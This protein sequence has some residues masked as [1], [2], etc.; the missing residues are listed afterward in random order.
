[1]GHSQQDDICAM[2]FSTVKLRRILMEPVMEWW[3]VM[4]RKPR[5]FWLPYFQNK[6]LAMT[7]VVNNIPTSGPTSLVMHIQTDQLI[8]RLGLGF[9]HREW[10]CP[11]Y[12]YIYI[13]TSYIPW[14]IHGAA[15]YGAPWIPS[16]YPSHVS[17]FLPAPAGSVMGICPW[18]WNSHW[19]TS[20]L[21]AVSNEYEFGYKSGFMPGKPKNF[22]ASLPNSSPSL[23][24]PSAIV[25][26]C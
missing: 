12:V 2:M 6:N 23:Y 18:W 16:I 10:Y 19:S 25:I 20:K 13:Y 5:Q 4:T 26:I 1:M 7:G 3:L 11:I 14:R 15:I 17:I 22:P 21:Q 8:R 9:V 24:K